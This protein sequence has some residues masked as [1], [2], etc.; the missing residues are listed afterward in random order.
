MRGEVLEA[1]VAKM[2]RSFSSHARLETRLASSLSYQASSADAQDA[3]TVCDA[4]DESEDGEHDSER[5]EAFAA[6]VSSEGG[7][8]Q[9]R[10]D[11]DKSHNNYPPAAGYREPR[12]SES[13]SRSGAVAD[14]KH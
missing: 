2:K 14:V 10:Y 8:Q 9:Y 13:R 11:R 4:G 6:F 12:S 3:G 1:L 5:G 7:K